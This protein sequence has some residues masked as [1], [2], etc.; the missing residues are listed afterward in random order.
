[1]CGIAGFI[2]EPPLPRKTA[3][4]LC[5]ALLY[6]S[7]DRGQQSAGIFVNNATIKKATSATN[8]I[9][10]PEYLT[11]FDKNPSYAITHTRQPT[12]GG[13]DSKH[14]Q[15]F[16]KNDTIT[17][18]NGFYS[19]CEA[20]KKQWNLTKSTNVDS[21]LVTQFIDSYGID[22]LPDFIDS[23]DGPSAIAALYRN[24]LYLIR[25]SNPT[26]Y[27]TLTTPG[28]S[29]IL[30]F[31]STKEILEKSLLRCWLIPKSISLE[32]PK[33]GILY[34]ATATGLTALTEN[35]V[36]HSYRMKPW[37]GHNYSHSSYLQGETPDDDE[38]IITHY[39]KYMPHYK[40]HE[41]DC[42]C[43]SCKLPHTKE[44]LCQSCEVKRFVEARK[45]QG[46]LEINSAD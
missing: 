43:L 21:E 28:N 7:Q 33:D 27:A 35:S 44:C 29:S 19:D 39:K 15:P 17:V 23:T 8:F 4:T 26:S 16:R 5:S 34:H 1:M 25:S 46:N 18:H 9:T 2:S 11:A 13:T 14:A 31:A 45:C 36:S 22:R 37:K 6:Y 12:S 30:V 38:S 32:I 10:S 42:N 40:P 20:L 41:K 3:R 24:N